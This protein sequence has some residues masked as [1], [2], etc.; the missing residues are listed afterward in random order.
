MLVKRSVMDTWGSVMTSYRC[1]AMSDIVARIEVEGI[2][3]KNR[4]VGNIINDLDR[5]AFYGLIRDFKSNIEE[6]NAEVKRDNE[7]LEK[8]ALFKGYISK[9]AATPQKKEF[10]RV[11]IGGNWQD[12]ARRFETATD[13]KRNVEIAWTE[14]N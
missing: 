8:I 5:R 2:S 7:E 3:V 14:W 4:Q 11:E 9:W 12:Y 10:I 1:N 6:Y 13:A